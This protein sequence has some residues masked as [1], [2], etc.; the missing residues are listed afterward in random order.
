MI[1]FLLLILSALFSYALVGA[2]FFPIFSIALILGV[3]SILV[4]SFKKPK[5]KYDYIWCGFSI[6][7]AAF[8]TIRANEFLMFLNLWAAMF[9]L[10]FLCEFHTFPF[11]GPFVR[12]LTAKNKYSFA[13]IFNRKFDSQ[14]VNFY[15]VGASIILALIIIP[16]LASANPIFNHLITETFGKLF[17]ENIV[18]HFFRI[19]IFAIFA[20]FIP[21]LISSV[22]EPAKQ[23]EIKNK[24]D[25]IS[26]KLLLPK[27][28]AII[29]LAV[30]F[31]TQIQLYFAST[32][33]LI[34]LG[35]T[36]S[37]HAREVFGQ[38]IVVSAIIGA[39][40]F[41]D[42][43]NSRKH[44]LTTTILLIEAVFL[45]LI[46]FKSVNDYVFAWGFTQKRLWGY[47]GVTYM[48]GVYSLF[49]F[50]HLKKLAHKTII[51]E[52]AIWSGI[53]LLGVNLANFDYLIYHVNQ[54]RTGD[55]VDY[56]YMVFNLSKD[57]HYYRDILGK[58]DFNKGSL[59]FVI[60]QIERLQNKYKNVDWRS[61][62][63]GEYLEYQD[64][65]DINTKDYS[66]P[67]IVIPPAPA[68]TACRTLGGGMVVDK[69]GRGY[70]GCDVWVDGAIDLSKSYCEGQI[71]HNTKLLIPDGYGRSNQYFA[72]LTG[73]KKNEEVKVFVYNSGG[74][75]IEC[76]PSL[77]NKK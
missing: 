16:L 5:T 46:A 56:E 11:F 29:I 17:K 42:K 70:I 38:L 44:W 73:L 53:I 2:K 15:S 23:S 76:L 49:T 7:F 74:E 8:L 52:I 59:G 10:S 9:S 4:I 72:T 35:L 43:S 51:K 64:I 25:E 13:H 77:N 57:G 18:I 3:I 48:A 65:K 27:I 28:V 39:L 22:N 1:N 69:N 63:L 12:V 67:L 58:I 14:V 20:F 40:V 60:N 75:K 37:Q 68:A 30:F 41:F 21:K 34:S 6:I 47:A 19:I 32:E 71:T 45:T 24:E 31:V 66:K 36:N 50:T 62:N 26:S 33:T 55:G 54:P 61:F